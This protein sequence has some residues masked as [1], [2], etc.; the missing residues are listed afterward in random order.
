M[1]KNYGF[2]YPEKKILVNIFQNNELLNRHS[3]RNN[4]TLSLLSLRNGGF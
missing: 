2:E 3:S 1:K 4:E